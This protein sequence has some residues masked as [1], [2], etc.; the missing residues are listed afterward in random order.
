MRIRSEESQD[1]WR[2]KIIR[3]ID[4]NENYIGVAEE[5]QDQW[6][7]KI[8]RYEFDDIITPELQKMIQ[9]V[10]PELLEKTKTI[11]TQTSEEIIKKT[12]IEKKDEKKE[13]IYHTTFNPFSGKFENV[14]IGSILSYDV[15]TKEWTYKLLQP[16]NSV[17]K[18]DGFVSLHSSY[19]PELL[20]INAIAREKRDKE[21]AKIGIYFG[22]DPELLKISK[23]VHDKKMAEYGLLF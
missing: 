7:N 21:M 16:K 2:N 12:S 5:S 8:T 17:D 14:P 1:Q 10:T 18:T 4:E 15:F 3:Y 23:S 9:N 6:G 11:A 19:D 22:K 20:K 13:T